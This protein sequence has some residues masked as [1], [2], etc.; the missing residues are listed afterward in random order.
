GKVFNR[1]APV[2]KLPAEAGEEEY[3]HLLGVLNSSTALFWLKQNSYPKGGDPMGD[4]G[5]R[6][7]QQPWSDRYEFTGTTLKDFPLVDADFTAIGRTLDQFATLHAAAQP[8]AVLSDAVPSAEMLSDAAAS[9]ASLRAEMIA[10]QEELDWF[11]YR[12]YGLTD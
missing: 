7:S 4:E 8:S 12:A 1:S 5:A 11:A 3:L 9:S 6:L 10:A 2:I